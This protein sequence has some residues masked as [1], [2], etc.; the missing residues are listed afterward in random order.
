MLESHFMILAVFSAL[1]SVFFASLTRETLME[2]VKVAGLMF[3]SM[4]GISLV[5]AY[6]MYFFPLG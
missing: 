2:G 6:L 4:V 1:V 5:L 3:I